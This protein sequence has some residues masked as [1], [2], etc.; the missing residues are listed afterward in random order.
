MDPD[1]TFRIAP[2]ERDTKRLSDGR[3]TFLS[4]ADIHEA[5]CP[6]P[7]ALPLSYATFTRRY[8]KMYDCKVSGQEE[9]KNAPILLRKRFSISPISK[10][11]SIQ[12]LG[13]SEEDILEKSK[14]FSGKVKADRAF[15]MERDAQAM[16][17]I[18]AMFDEVLRELQR[19]RPRLRP[20]RD[21]GTFR[22]IDAKSIQSDLACSACVLQ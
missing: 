7:C 6:P 9:T 17:K 15:A 20:P 3:D 18:R 4:F 12:K 8:D 21:K 2:H 1:A 14:S 11:R 13:R 16:I 5:M 10:K 22:S 19:T